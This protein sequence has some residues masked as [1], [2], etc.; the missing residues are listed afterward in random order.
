MKYLMWLL[1]ATIFFTLFSFALNNQQFVVVHFFFGTLWK[2]PLVLVVL[3]A[4]ALGLIFGILVMMPRW[5]KKHS[6]T[7]INLNAQPH[8]SNVL[9]EPSSLANAITPSDNSNI[10]RH[11]L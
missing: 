4:F 2:S 9:N 1:R 5:W 11:G 8:S 7:N 10:A 6:A 3:A